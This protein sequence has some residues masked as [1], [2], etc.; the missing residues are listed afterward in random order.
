[1]NLHKHNDHEMVNINKHIM[2]CFNDLFWAAQK[3]AYI[4][5]L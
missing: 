4:S 1:M 2:V 5:L 3:E